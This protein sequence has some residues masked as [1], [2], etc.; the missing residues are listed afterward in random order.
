MNQILLITL[1]GLLAGMLGTGLGGVVTF[2]WRSPSNKGVSFLLGFAG[3]IMLTIVMV[4]LLPE[5]VESSSIFHAFLGTL[6]GFVILRVLSKFFSRYVKGQEYIQTGILL[7]VGISLHN[8]PEGLA[9]GAGCAATSELG[10]GLALIMMLHNF[11]EGL[12]M[13]TPMN[14]GGWRPAKIFLLTLLPG[15]PMGIGACAGAIIGYVSP[16]FLAITLG[17]S[18]GGMLYL[19]IFELIPSAY[20]FDYGLDA[21]FG[22][23]TG[24]V[25]GVFLIFLL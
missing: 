4:D 21:S 18:G 7:A 22:I 3:G 11:P 20:D 25:T 9:I 2:F 14:V 6:L 8:F 24:M 15:I 23:V 10:V 17:F 13:A 19:T 12:S 16:I 1:I 5:A